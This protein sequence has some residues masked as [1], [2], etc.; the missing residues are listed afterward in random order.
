MGFRVHPNHS[1]RPPV[2]LASRW[3]SDRSPRPAPTLGSTHKLCHHT[4]RDRCKLLLPLPCGVQLSTGGVALP[5]VRRLSK[6]RQLINSCA[7]AIGLCTRP[8]G[9]Q[10]V[11]SGQVTCWAYGRLWLGPAAHCSKGCIDTSLSHEG[12]T[13][14]PHTPAHAQ[15]GVGTGPARGPG[16]LGCLPAR[17]ARLLSGQDTGCCIARCLTGRLAG[18]KGRGV[19]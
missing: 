6:E 1:N 2:E 9:G 11:A 3:R 7:M 13:S 18:G 8:R 12:V 10:R 15:R 5:A 19:A 4:G 16:G 17:A 14:A